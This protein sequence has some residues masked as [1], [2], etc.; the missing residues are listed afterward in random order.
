MMIIYL[1]LPRDHQWGDILKIQSSFCPKIVK[2]DDHQLVYMTKS[3][4]KLSFARQT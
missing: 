2:E 1:L 3:Y 4:K